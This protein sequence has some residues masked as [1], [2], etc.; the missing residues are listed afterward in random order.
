M[1]L[2]MEIIRLDYQKIL[3]ILDGKS[4]TAINWITDECDGEKYLKYGATKLSYNSLTNQELLLLYKYLKSLR[5]KKIIYH[6]GYKDYIF[7]YRG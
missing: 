4:E 7:F 3:N 6:L 2:I 1:T 5:R